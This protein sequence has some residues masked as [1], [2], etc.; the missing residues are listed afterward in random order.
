MPPSSPALESPI[1]R[2]IHC[3]LCLEHCPTYTLHR[4]E[5]NSPRGRLTIWRALQDG[6]LTHSERTDFLTDECVGCLACEDNCPSNVPYGRILATVRAQRVAAGHRPALMVRLAAALVPHTRTFQWLN[7]PARLLRR[8]HCL[9]HR[10]VFPGAPAVLRSSAG[11]A[12]KL[13]ARH[14]PSGPKVALFTGC[15]M[16]GLFREINFATIRV[17]IANNVQVVVPRGQA[18]CGALAEHAGLPGRDALDARNQAAFDPLDV[19]CVIANSAGCGLALK[20]GIAKPVVDVMTFL[21]GLD[22]R[23]GTKPATDHAYVD[24]P[25]HLCHGLRVR[26]VPPGIFAAMD[27]PWSLT[28]HAEDCCGAGGTYHLVKPQNARAILRRQAEFLKDVPHAHC[29]VTTVNHVCMMQWH[30][31]RAE[32]GRRRVAV[33][34]LVQLLDEAYG[35]ER[36]LRRLLAGA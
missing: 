30:S 28:P 1:D 12:A 22:L 27:L 18:C 13:M 24:L 35:G 36:G 4:Q 6:R 26:A 33:K 2:C 11:Y 9:P 29:T 15:L 23:P 19:D 20:E 21:G 32:V 8:L 5:P 10:L 34:H 25:C 17:L 14:R 16:E 3:G 31:A 7:A